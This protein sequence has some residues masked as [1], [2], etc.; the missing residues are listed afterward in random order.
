MLKNVLNSPVVYQKFQEAGGFFSARVKAIAEFLT[1]TPG[2]RVLDIGCGPGNIV[3]HLPDG[4][5]YIG[6]D[7]DQRYIQHAQA[8]F[9]GRGRFFCQQFDATTVDLVAP[10]DVA[11]MNGVIHHISDDALGPLLGAIKASLR[12]GGVLL[13]L[14][15]CYIPDQSWFNK[16]M[17]DQDRGRFV[18]DEEGYRRVLERTFG[19]VALHIREHYSWVPYTFIAG[20]SRSLAENSAP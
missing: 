17:L 16:W 2:M 8:R 19:D 15:G 20:L 12:Q 4:V 9:A 10:V 13:T 5:D 18:R 1:I 3:E 6:F 7:I 11:M 14:D